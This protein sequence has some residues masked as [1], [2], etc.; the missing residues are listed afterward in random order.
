MFARRAADSPLNADETCG[1]QVTVPSGSTT[2]SYR[3]TATRRQCR[4]PPV[5]HRY[6]SSDATTQHRADDRMQGGR[7]QDPACHAVEDIVGYS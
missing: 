7:R 5:S 1:R 4:G 2:L 3:A 6:G